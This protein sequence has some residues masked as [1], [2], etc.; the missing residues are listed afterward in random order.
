MTNDLPRLS[1]TGAIS[2]LV[3]LEAHVKQYKLVNWVPDWRTGNSLPV[4]HG[5]IKGG[6]FVCDGFIDLYADMPS[7]MVLAGPFR[8]IEEVYQWRREMSDA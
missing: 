4:Y 1:T 3:E 7:A 8:T 2:H 6:Y 5:L